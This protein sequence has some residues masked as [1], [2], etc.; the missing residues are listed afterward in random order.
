MI[1]RPNPQAVL[2]AVDWLEGNGLRRRCPT[3]LDESEARHVVL[4]VVASNEL[5]PDG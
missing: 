5:R 3:E 2:A 1:A 4:L